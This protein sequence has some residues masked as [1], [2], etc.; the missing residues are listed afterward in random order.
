LL[1]HDIVHQ[2][3]K[4]HPLWQKAGM[5]VEDRMN[6]MLLPTTEGTKY[7]TT[8]RTVHQGR[9]NVDVKRQLE[10]QMNKVLRDG[11]RLNF[12]QEQYKEALETII[13][14]EGQSLMK[15]ERVLNNAK[16]YRK[17]GN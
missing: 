14:K 12:T 6:K 3:I 1:R 8:S 9:H 15:G 2:N 7:T 4:K 11:E 16:D 5:T 13:R 10:D 17:V